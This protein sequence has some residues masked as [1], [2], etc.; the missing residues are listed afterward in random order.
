MGRRV[1][2]EQA[3]GREFVAFFGT[4][5]AGRLLG[6][7]VL[8]QIKLAGHEPTR[9]VILR[10]GWGSTAARYRNVAQLLRFRDAME[11]KGWTFEDPEL[12]ESVPALE[13]V[14]A[15]A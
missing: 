11:A 14:R 6:W 7:M 10:D 3:F 13:L 1:M 5:T 4:V 8:T 12:L 2:D 9:E 15:V